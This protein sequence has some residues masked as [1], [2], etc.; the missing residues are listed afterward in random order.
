M[1]DKREMVELLLDFFHR[2]TMHHAMWFSEVKHQ[3]G[4]EKAFK[5][6]DTALTQSRNIQLKRLSKVLGFEMEENIPAPLL[7]MEEETLKELLDAASI[8]WLANDGVWFQT[9]E[10]ADNMFDAKRC[11][12]SC[13]TQFSPFEAWS[14]K[15]LIGLGDQPG[16]DGLKEALKLRLYAFINEQSIVDETDTSFV[17]QMNHCRVQDARKRKGLNDYP[18][19]SAGMVEY[20]RFAAAIDKRIK[21]RCIGCPP[22]AHP[23]EWF[24]AWEFTLEE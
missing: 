18:C 21:T 3:M 5:A 22:D 2:T 12:D 4:E 13:W 1:N 15:R 8:N 19:K 20:P 23:E 24:C 14:I 6:L 10:F 16:L 9:V 7:N 17:F 11:N